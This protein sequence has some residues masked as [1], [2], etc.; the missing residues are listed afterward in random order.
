A[1]S[2]PGDPRLFGVSARG[3]ISVFD[4]TQQLAAPFLDL[5]PASGGPVVDTSKGTELGLL[6]LVFHP[7]YADNGVFF[8]YYTSGD[9]AAGTLRDVVA[10]CAVSAQ[11]RNVAAPSC[12][13]ILAMADPA[14]NHN[15]G[16]MEFG[17]DGMLYIGTGDGGGTNENP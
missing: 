10:R 5:S 15:G 9:P 7:G 17:S 1:A 13:E 14:V 3:K 8:V 11:D 12:V 16:M 4:G 2:P 6:G